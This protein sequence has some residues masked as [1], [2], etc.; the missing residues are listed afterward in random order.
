MSIYLIRGVV[1]DKVLEQF[2]IFNLH[3]TSRE[4]D[5]SA[6]RQNVFAL[7]DAEWNA[8]ED[9]FR[10]LKLSQSDLMFYYHEAKTAVCHFL[11]WFAA[12]GKGTA[13]TKPWVQKTLFNHKYRVRGRVDMIDRSPYPP[14]IIDWKT[15][16]SKEVTE[17][18]KRQLVLYAFMYEEAFKVR[19][20]VGAHFLLFKDGFRQFKVSDTS[21]AKI[22]ET[23]LNV[24]HKTQSKDINEYPCTCGYCTDME[25]KET[26]E[27][28]KHAA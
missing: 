13:Y 21:I 20:G 17:A 15:T 28:D 2:Y 1:V 8:H 25:G 3:R 23:I 11:E 24:H 18:I 6:V 16:K 12:Q 14:L 4:M 10:A 9:E 22:K 27:G 5:F 7:L 19:P 26:N